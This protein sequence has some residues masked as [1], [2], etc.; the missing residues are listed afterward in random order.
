MVNFYIDNSIIAQTIFRKTLP[1]GSSTSLIIGDN[2]NLIKYLEFS[3]KIKDMNPDEGIAYLYDF[4]ESD[5]DWRLVLEN[6]YKWISKSGFDQLYFQALEIYYRKILTYQTSPLIFKPSNDERS[7]F[8]L[9]NLFPVRDPLLHLETIC[10]M[11]EKILTNPLSSSQRK[12]VGDKIAE[13]SSNNLP[14][15]INLEEVLHIWRIISRLH[16][17]GRV[18]DQVYVDRTLTDET[19][20]CKYLQNA[21]ELVRKG[22][23]R[24]DYHHG[25]YT[26]VY[27]YNSYWNQ[28][29]NTPN[30]IVF[31]LALDC[32]IIHDHFIQSLMQGDDIQEENWDSDPLALFLVSQILLLEIGTRIC[33]LSDDS[34]SQELNIWGAWRNASPIIPICRINVKINDSSENIVEYQVNERV[35]EFDTDK[36]VPINSQVEKFINWFFG[37]SCLELYDVDRKNSKI[38]FCWKVPWDLSLP[39][40][41]EE[42]EVIIHSIRTKYISSLNKWDNNGKIDRLIHDAIPNYNISDFDSR[43]VKKKNEIRKHCIKYAQNILKSFRGSVIEDFSE[44]I[45]LNQWN[46]KT[47]N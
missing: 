39:K 32:I 33:W 16:D 41:L 37:S 18:I 36:Y 2:S 44:L 42:F 15:P 6:N 21:I 7:N 11:G 47:K 22:V 30:K 40:W 28:I 34:E 4:E 27:L 29:K 45:M 5:Y 13:I 17:V 35:R 12:L 23:S 46:E 19:G 43:N 24:W 10:L 31:A 14:N 26:A 3:E 9:G 8:H 1:L 20:I 38:T 25:I